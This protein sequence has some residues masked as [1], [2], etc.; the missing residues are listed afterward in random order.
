[1]PLR[2]VRQ[3]LRT[4]GGTPVACKED[5]FGSHGLL[6]FKT[7]A[8]LR[9]A[10]ISSPIS[11]VH[12]I[13]EWDF[14]PRRRHILKRSH[15]RD[16]HLFRRKLGAEIVAPRLRRWLRAHRQRRHSEDQV[17]AWLHG[18]SSHPEHVDGN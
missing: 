7:A 1:M 13:V 3:P 14:K 16:L 18:S 8:T 11:S 2:W 15:L 5:S 6:G 9:L 17:L 4:A 12:Y 10:I